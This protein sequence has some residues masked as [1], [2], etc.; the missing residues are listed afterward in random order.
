MFATVIEPRAVSPGIPLDLPAVSTPTS[1]R[2]AGRKRSPPPTKDPYPSLHRLSTTAPTDGF[3]KSL[4]EALQEEESDDEDHGTYGRAPDWSS[5]AGNLELVTS[6]SHAASQAQTHAGGRSQ[7]PPAEDIRIMLAS[8]G[9]A[10]VEVLRNKVV[11]SLTLKLKP[12]WMNLNGAREALMRGMGTTRKLLFPDAKRLPEINELEELSAEGGEDAPTG[13]RSSTTAAGCEN[14]AEYRNLM[15]RLCDLQFICIKAAVD[16]S[17]TGEITEREYWLPLDEKQTVADLK[18]LVSG[19]DALESDGLRLL[20]GT[21]S[22]SDLSIV[23]AGRALDDSHTVSEEGLTHN[24][25]VHLFVKKDANI[26]VKMCGTKDLEVTLNANETAESLRAKLAVLSVDQPTDSQ[27]FYGGQELKDGPLNMYGIADG[28]TLELRPFTAARSI[29]INPATRARHSWNASAN[30]GWKSG[31]SSTGN[32]GSWMSNMSTGLTNGTPSMSV[33][34]PSN[35]S[36]AGTSDSGGSGS[37]EGEILGESPVHVGSPDLARSFDMARQGLLMG[38]RPQLASGGTGGAYFL[39]DRDGETCAVFKPADEEPCAKNNPRGNA[40]TSANGEGLRKGT[41]VGEGA[42]RE[43]AAYV[44]DHGGFAGVPATSLAHLGEMRRSS[45]GKDLGGK[46]GSLQAYVRADA[47]AEEL[48]PGLFPVHE[49]HKIAQLDIRLANTDRN[50]GNILVQKEANTMKLVPIDHGYSLPHTL[51]D[52]CFE[53]EFWPQA[54]VPFS[55]DTRAYVAAIDVDADVELLRE[56][57]I[58]LLPSSERVL[59]V[60]TTLLK[61]ATKQGCCPADIAGM[62]SR[63]MPNRMSDLE[64][65]TS[66]AASAAAASVRAEDG[67]VVHRP[68]NGKGDGNAWQ[69]LDGTER[70]EKRFMVEYEKL[71]DDYLEGFEPE[72][73][74]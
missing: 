62:M 71:L 64:K 21:E 38:K 65:L 11:T 45:S 35:G 23:H 22:S 60:C 72:M 66:R 67:L 12:D 17:D 59:R 54:K 20:A 29:P 61:R 58:E 7:T 74:L 41:R 2:E 9:A 53:W 56:H 63:P 69:E 18:T 52:V 5:Y 33:S 24:A 37:Y 49:V 46:L 36:M 26:T 14:S 27:L 42:S 50:A 13:T 31:M 3:H 73:D 28:S 48:G 40:N 57:G 1:S 70:L 68:M 55:E 15:M 10:P 25:V 8:G 43:V 16:V 32:P 6:P 4:L 19:A 51:E 44:L 34:I 39:R 47:E 30:P